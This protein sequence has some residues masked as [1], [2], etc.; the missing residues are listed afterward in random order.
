MLRDRLAHLVDVGALLADHDARTGGVDRHAALAV[1]T[2]D[3]D[4]RDRR[5]LQVSFISAARILMSSCSSWPYSFLLAN[6][7]LSHVRLMPRRR[8]IGI[9]LLTHDALLRPSLRLR[10]RRWS[11]SRTA[12]RPDRPGHGRARVEPL[13]HQRLADER[14]GD[15]EV[16]DVEVVVVL[17][18]GDGALERL[19]DARPSRSRLR[20]NSRSAS[21]V[22]TFLPR[23][24]PATRLSFCGDTRSMRATALASLSFKRAGGGRLAHGL[25]PLGLLVGRVPVEGTGR[26]ELA[27][28]VADHLFR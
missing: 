13:H 14:L 27:E 28:L 12:S 4:L 2:L 10:G 26:G 7:R 5:L 1:R 19:L 22:D 23:I 25:L 16:V 9:D 24:R 3:D 6:Q 21:A 15:D 18:I 20:E 11:G 17:G 8:P